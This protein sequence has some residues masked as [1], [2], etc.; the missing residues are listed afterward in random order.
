MRLASQ[1]TVS[2]QDRIRRGFSH[3]PGTAVRPGK[4]SAV[5]YD[6][7]VYFPLSGTVKITQKDSLPGT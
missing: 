6:L 5:R 2:H 4:S 1:S 3:N 7:N